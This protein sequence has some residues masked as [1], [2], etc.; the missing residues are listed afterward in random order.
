MALARVDLAASGSV[1]EAAAWAR[2][3]GAGLPTTVSVDDVREL[4]EVLKY[5]TAAGQPTKVLL[6]ALESRLPPEERPKVPSLADL[7]VPSLVAW[8]EQQYAGSAAGHAQP[9]PSLVAMARATDAKLDLNGRPRRPA[10]L[11][12][13]QREAKMTGGFGLATASP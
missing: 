11:P 13:R 9:A 3:L 4:V 1:E 5:P 6:Q 12:G 7:P 8:L 10:P 2:L